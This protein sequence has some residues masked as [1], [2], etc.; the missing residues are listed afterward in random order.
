MG[1]N[2]IVD[3]LRHYNGLWSLRGHSIQVSW[4]VELGYEFLRMLGGVVIMK[5]RPRNA[6][7]NASDILGLFVHLML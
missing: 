1:G 4:W 6:G 5:K 3:N 7:L 2:K